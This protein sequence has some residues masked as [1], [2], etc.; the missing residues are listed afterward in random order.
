MKSRLY[1][2]HVAHTR[3]RPRHHRLRYP[4][5]M[6]G[7]D[8]D[9]LPDLDRRLPLFGYNTFRPSSVHDRDYVHGGAGSI[10][11]KLLERLRNEGVTEPVERVTLI[12]SARYFHYVFNPVSFYYCYGAG[13][14]LAAVVAEVNNTYGERHLYV[15]R[16]AVFGPRDDRSYFLEEKAF[17][18]SPYNDMEG[19]YTFRLS[20]AAEDLDI[21]I[22]LDRGGEHVF[23]ASLAA[24]SVP[25]TPWNH[26]RVMLRHPVVPHLSIP[27]I[28]WQAFLLRFQKKL[29]F[30]DKPAPVSPS[31]IPRMTRFQRICRRAVRNAL[32]RIESGGLRLGFPGGPTERFGEPGA[33]AAGEIRVNDPRFFSRIAL[34][35]DIGLGE[36]YMFGEWDSPDLV[37]LFSVLI[38]NRDRLSDG[39]WAASMP[40]RIAERMS[41]VVRKNSV[42][43]S[44][45]NIREHYDLGNDFY[46]LFLDRSM[47]YSCAVFADGE[48]RLH[49]AQVHK[50]HL[51][52]E[53]A[54]ISRQ[55]H[56]LEIGCGWGGF[57]IEAAKR[58]G[59]RVTGITVSEEQARYAREWVLREGLQDRIDIRV[60]DY[61]DL[62]ETFDKIVAIEMLEAVG[63]RYIPGFFRICDRLLGDGGT[64]VVQTITVPDSRYASYRRGRDWIQK[65]I[66]P[67][68]HL[69]CVGLLR[70]VIDRQ[71]SF[72]IQGMEEIGS[73][74][75][76]TLRHWRRRLEENRGR[77]SSMGYGREF[78]RKWRY[79][80][81]ICEAGFANDAI[82]DVQ[83][84]LSRLNA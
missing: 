29:T 28:Y 41:H 22:D 30:H 16:E 63:E 9:E 32:G 23:E 46:S 20:E 47:T 51:M 70:R 37:E 31:T 44:R 52:I 77:I 67:G 42:P 35:G 5:Y 66:F 82:G 73:H 62:R 4:L 26:A 1:L 81:S 59:C 60:Q 34:Q 14:G 61:R 38:R 54:G 10:K 24:R 11:Q 78:F 12:T 56:V 72:T 71:T 57:S 18:V 25:L 68:G 76:R 15:L 45:R 53:K 79:Y 55:D 13:G 40:A 80:F 69:P 64:A 74:Y 83:M 75:A 36:S 21:G 65:H 84:V 6:Y 19:T 33:D 48:D 17:H 58:T 39:N 49:S 43:G 8:L 2:G 50:H 27:R 7:L 3:H